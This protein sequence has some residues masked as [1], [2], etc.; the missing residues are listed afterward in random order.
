MP[1]RR[2]TLE[3]WFLVHQ[4]HHLSRRH[5]FLPL[6]VEADV[7]EVAARWGGAPPYTAVLVKALAMTARAH[8]AINRA[9]F[10]TFWGTRVV[11]FDDVRVNLPVLVSDAQGRTHLAATVIDRADERPVEAIREALRAARAR[12]SEDLPIG[13]VFVANRNTLWNRLRLRLIHFVVWNAPGLYVRK[14][15]GGLGVSSLLLLAEPD[16]AGWAMAYGPTAFTAISCSVTPEA[17]RVRMRVGVGYDHY[18]LPGHEALA[19]VRTLGRVLA[20]GE[21]LGPGGGD[22]V[23]VQER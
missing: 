15:G 2:Q 13:R 5:F 19:A 22:D 14:G 7:T 18:A 9:V 10:R 23:S 11:D 17:G 6:H 3:E 20:A 8:P 1:I 21:G 12:R 4:L 16:F